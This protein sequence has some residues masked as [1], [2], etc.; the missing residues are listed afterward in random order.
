MKNWALL[1]AVI[2]FGAFADDCQLGKRQNFNLPIEL[3]EITI[4]QSYIS[5]CNIKETTEVANINNKLKTL[6]DS[7]DPFFEEVRSNFSKVY[8]SD[9]WLVIKQAFLANGNAYLILG[10][11]ERKG[12]TYIKLKYAEGKIVLQNLFSLRD[13]FGIFL[14]SVDSA[15]PYKGKKGINPLEVF[16]VD[17]VYIDVTI[18]EKDNAFFMK[19]FEEFEKAMLKNDIAYIE[20]FFGEKSITKINEWLAKMPNDSIKSNSLRH[21]VVP[22][23]IEKVI[24]IGEVN[25]VYFSKKNEVENRLYF[26]NGVFYNYMSETFLDSVLWQLVEQ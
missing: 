19:K 24:K 26:Y 9:D 22:G 15:K 16:E 10:S 25:I 5:I 21:Y 6:K 18:S 13:S 23:K 2:S 14:M 1:V 8:E 4:D 17:K 11:N 3:D 20:N 7:N 12:F